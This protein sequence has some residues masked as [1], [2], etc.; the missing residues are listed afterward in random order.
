MIGGRP[1]FDLLVAWFEGGTTPV[2][3]G[4]KDIGECLLFPL[5]ILVYGYKYVHT[6]IK[7]SQM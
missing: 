1:I 7:P 2:A 3:L 6:N 5:S 4:G